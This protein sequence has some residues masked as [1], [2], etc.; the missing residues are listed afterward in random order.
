M[1]GDDASEGEGIM[2]EK[3]VTEK[4]LMA[5]ND[6]FVDI[7]NVLLFEADVLKEE[8]LRSGGTESV[9]KEAEK[10]RIQQRD[11]VKE[12]GE[13]YETQCV[14]GIENQ[15]KIDLDMPI[16]IMG[17]DYGSYRQMVD[18]DTERIP[19]ITIV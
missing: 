5:F 14:L 19:V 4:Y 17:Y 9:Y 11:V 10:S 3:D 15:S 7:Y 6:V 2:G 1:Y 13:G 18:N 16:R 12:Y 8:Y